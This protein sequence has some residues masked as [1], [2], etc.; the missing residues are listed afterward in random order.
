MVQCKL[1]DQGWVRALPSVGR[2]DLHTTLVGA[3]WRPAN[4]CCTHACMNRLVRLA[5]NR[6]QSSSEGKSVMLVVLHGLYGKRAK[7]NPSVNRTSTSGLRPL[8]AAG[9]LKR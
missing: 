6:V 9:Y 3:G 1:S 7:P 5:H 8:A 4:L 2:I